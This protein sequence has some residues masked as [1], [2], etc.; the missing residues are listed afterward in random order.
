MVG[1]CKFER[2][3]KPEGVKLLT[4]ISVYPHR[5]GTV[6]DRTARRFGYDV[7]NHIVEHVALIQVAMAVGVLHGA[8]MCAEAAAVLKLVDLAY[9][10]LDGEVGLEAGACCERIFYASEILGVV[11]YILAHHGL[12][13]HLSHI[14]F[15]IVARFIVLK[16]LRHSHKALTYTL[17]E[18][19]IADLY[20]IPHVEYLYT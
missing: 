3:F 1:H 10:A 15:K 20:D 16:M 11:A 17:R 12:H 5:V 8:V 2:H 13:F 6:G 19:L 14:I 7:E 4:Q 18:L 9:I